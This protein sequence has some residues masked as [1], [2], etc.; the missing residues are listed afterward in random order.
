[1]QKKCITQ[2]VY[3]FEHIVYLVYIYEVYILQYT[4][5]TKVYTKSTHFW[6]L[7]VQYM[8]YLSALCDLCILYTFI[9]FLY[10]INVAYVNLEQSSIHRASDISWEKKAKFRGV[11]RGKFAE[12]STAFA[13]FL[14]E[15]SRNSLKNLPISR[16]KSQSPQKNRP[17]TRDFSGKKSNFKGYSEA[18]SQKNRPI[19]PEISGETSPRNILTMQETISKKSQFRWIFFG[20]ISLKSINF[21][22]I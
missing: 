5:G 9:Y 10:S 13:R 3:K 18:N 7:F 19:S 4:F 12:K 8:S 21:A 22:S 15:K 14:R 16:E 20:Q 6:T 17:I 2:N 1:M 11:F